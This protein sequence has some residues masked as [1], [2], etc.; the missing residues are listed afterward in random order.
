MVESMKRED[1]PTVKEERAVVE[2]VTAPAAPRNILDRRNGL[3]HRRAPKALRSA[4]RRASV[5]RVLP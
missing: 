2:S 1:R 3:H 5:S 4:P